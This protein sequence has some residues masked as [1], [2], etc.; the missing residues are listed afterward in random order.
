MKIVKLDVI[1]PVVVAADTKLKRKSRKTFPKGILKRTA[2]ILPTNS[3][4]VLKNSRHTIIRF[5]KS[6]K[7]KTVRNKLKKMSEDQ[8][9]KLAKV[10]KKMPLAQVTEIV[11]GGMMTGMISAQ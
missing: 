8:I 7:L 3:P 6:S 10:S 2:R 5:G 9:R 4:T 11:E 1:A